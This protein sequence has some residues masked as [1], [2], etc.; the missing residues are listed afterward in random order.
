ML[1]LLNSRRRKCN[2]ATSADVSGCEEREFI[3]GGVL[4]SERKLNGED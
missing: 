2:K 4:E 1:D 3:G